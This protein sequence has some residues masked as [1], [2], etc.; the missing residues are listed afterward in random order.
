MNQVTTGREQEREIMRNLKRWR[1]VPNLAAAAALLAFAG[2]ETSSS[3]D[4]RS[5]G[6]VTDD[7]EITANVEKELEREPVYKFQNVEAKTFAGVVQ[8]SGF[9]D[10]EAQKNRAGEIAQ[11]IRG[12]RQVENGIALKPVPAPM[13]APTGS[14]NGARIYSD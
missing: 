11:G 7:K 8:L 12:V 9:V 6:R 14:T 5:D 2:C 4:Q 13:M 3:H 1:L 10:I